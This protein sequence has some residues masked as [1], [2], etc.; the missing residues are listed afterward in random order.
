MTLSNVYVIPHGDE[1]IDVPDQESR[2]MQ[3]M[4]R[5]LSRS[6]GSETVVILSPHGIRISD[7]VGVVTTEYSKGDQVFGRKRVR[8]RFRN[9]ISLATEIAGSIP[10]FTRSVSFIT[11]SGPKSEFPLDFGTLIPLSFF[12]PERV[13]LIGQPRVRDREKLMRFGRALYSAVSDRDYGVSVI[14]SADQAHTHARDG[15]Y[16]FSESAAEYESIVVCAIKSNDFSSLSKIT[17]KMI[18]EAKPDSFW[19]M[20]IL[21]GFIEASRISLVYDFNYVEHYFGML[22]AHSA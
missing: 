5:S 18:D 6:D 7:S 10:G 21:K 19:N 14:F 11:S 17:D 13:V 2:K 3:D 9:D 8:R 4:I 1:L 22:L 12:K 20:M 15:P 16:G